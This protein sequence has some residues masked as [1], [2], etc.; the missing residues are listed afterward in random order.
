MFRLLIKNIITEKRSGKR[1]VLSR[2]KSQRQIFQYNHTNKF[3]ESI[4]KVNIV[5]QDIGSG[6]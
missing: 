1:T 6:C 5:P 3:V 2:L 4:V